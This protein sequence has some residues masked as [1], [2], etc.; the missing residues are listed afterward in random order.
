M[1]KKMLPRGERSRSEREARKFEEQF[2]WV[3]CGNLENVEMPKRNDSKL[4][5]EDKEFAEAALG[6]KNDE[7]AIAN[8][9][10]KSMPK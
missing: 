6:S 4:D 9:K 5:K 10:G 1:K 3:N 2:D 8:A 7:V